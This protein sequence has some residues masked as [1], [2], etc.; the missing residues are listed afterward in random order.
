[1]T[2]MPAKAMT[3]ENASR[4]ARHRQDRRHVRMP[5]SVK[6]AARIAERRIGRQL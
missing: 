2:T 6:N 5:I 3:F 4:V 1:M